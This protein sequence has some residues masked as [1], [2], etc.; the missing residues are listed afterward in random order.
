MLAAGCI[1]YYKSRDNVE[2]HRSKITASLLKALMAGKAVIISIKI[3][4]KNTISTI[5]RLQKSLT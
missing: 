4:L 2:I 5:A 3:W 1:P